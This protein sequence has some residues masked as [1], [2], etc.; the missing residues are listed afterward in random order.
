MIVKLDI[1]VTTPDTESNFVPCLLN[2]DN[3][4]S[5][6]PSGIEGVLNVEMVGGTKVMARTEYAVFQSAS[7]K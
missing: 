1:R 3:V 4:V 7:R 6:I 5:V 2:T